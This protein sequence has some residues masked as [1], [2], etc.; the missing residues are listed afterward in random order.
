MWNILPILSSTS[1][2]VILSERKTL[3]GKLMP[4]IA[5]G[6]FFQIWLLKMWKHWLMEKEETVG[7]V[8]EQVDIVVSIFLLEE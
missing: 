8:V 5:K 3:I 2:S 1:L 7:G 4:I 6:V